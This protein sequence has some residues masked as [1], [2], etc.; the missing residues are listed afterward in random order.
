MLRNRSLAL[1]ISSILGVA[2]SIY[3]LCIVFSLFLSATGLDSTGALVVTMLMAP[4]VVCV[5]LAT[6]FNILAFWF[7]SKGFAI[8]ASVLYAVGGLVFF[9]YRLYV[10]PMVLIT[11]IGISD[12]S[13]IKRQNS[14][15]R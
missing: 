2:Y 5:I 4:H 14:D 12:V 8:A 3:I 10:I 13:K 6:L 11:L 9:T 7:T 1:F 15:Q